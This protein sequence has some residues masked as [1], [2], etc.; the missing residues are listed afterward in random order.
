MLSSETS[1]VLSIILRIHSCILIKEFT[2]F[3]THV[4]RLPSNLCK[5]CSDITTPLATAVFSKM[6]QLHD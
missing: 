3:I 6:M 2:L 4:K 1:P 5:T